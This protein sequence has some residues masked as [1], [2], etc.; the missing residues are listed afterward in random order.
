MNEKTDVR[1]LIQLIP[2]TY[3]AGLRLLRKQFDQE[4]LGWNPPTEVPLVSVLASIN[5]QRGSDEVRRGYAAEELL[6]DGTHDM[7]SQGVVSPPD[8]N[9]A[10]MREVEHRIPISVQT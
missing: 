1:P 5:R 2:L 4:R 8:S 7:F 10:E 6:D 9:I 3:L